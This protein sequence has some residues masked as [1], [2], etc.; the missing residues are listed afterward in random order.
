MQKHFKTKGRNVL[1][2]IT[3]WAALFT[4]VYRPAACWRKGTVKD[5]II[6]MTDELPLRLK[7]E[8][9]MMLKLL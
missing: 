4:T 7:S 5:A 9:L 1:N 8:G 6:T 3:E 2:T